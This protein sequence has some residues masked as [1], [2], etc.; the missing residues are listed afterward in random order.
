[1][2]C[3]TNELDSETVYH[4]MKSVIRYVKH[5]NHFLQLH[6]DLSQVISPSHAKK[7]T[8]NSDKMKLSL[9]APSISILQVT[10][11]PLK[12]ELLKLG[13]IGNDGVQTPPTHYGGPDLIGR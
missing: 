1:M 5:L 3:H 12:L 10:K 4:V 8:S 2:E 13:R 11:V 9:E 7:R 6:T